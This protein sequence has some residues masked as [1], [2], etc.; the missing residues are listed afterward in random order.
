MSDANLKALTATILDRC[1]QLGRLSDEALPR[2][3]RTFLGPATAAVHRRVGEW[4]AAAGMSVRVDGI[5][6]VIG[7]YE[8]ASP[9][10]PALLIGSHLD[11]VPDAG[12]FD[13]VLGVMLGLAAVEALGRQRLPIAI[14]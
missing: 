11:T 10:A 2:L 12:K 9:G 5:G 8:G 7:R 4:M 1:D 13:G 14:E 6:N 3:T